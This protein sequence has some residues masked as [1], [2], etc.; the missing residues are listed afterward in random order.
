MARW[1]V[2]QAAQDAG[3]H[4]VNRAIELISPSKTRSLLG[5]NC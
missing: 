4:R 2:L 3:E 1:T 5:S